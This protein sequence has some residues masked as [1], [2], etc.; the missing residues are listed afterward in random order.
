[1]ARITKCYLKKTE[2]VTSGSLMGPNR[3]KTQDSGTGKSWKTEGGCNNIQSACRR[4]AKRSERG[5]RGDAEVAPQAV[6]RQLAQR[7]ARPIFSFPHAHLRL[8]QLL[9]HLHTKRLQRRH[10]CRL[11]PHTTRSL[12]FMLAQVFHRL[13]PSCFPQGF[14][15][16]LN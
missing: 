8:K 5:E 16:P 2:Q 6:K 4:Q 14:F 1:M 7:C 11:L 13:S 9:E 3:H 15:S 10:S 12:N